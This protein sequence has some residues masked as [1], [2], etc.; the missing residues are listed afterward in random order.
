VLAEACAQLRA[1]REQDLLLEYVAV[2]VSPRQFRKPGRATAVAGILKQN[3]LVPSVL[4]LEITEGVLFDDQPSASA[5]FSAL[6]ALGVSL[7][8]DDFGTGYSSLARLQRLPVAVVKLDRSFISGI[9]RNAGAQAVVRAAIDMSH[10]LGKYVVAEGVEDAAQ[11]ALLSAMGCD[12][13]Q[14]F[15]ISH[16]LPAAELAPFVRQQAAA[17]APRSPA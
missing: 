14:G 1:W 4:H 9:E 11:L 15:H 2:N 3:E 16:P 17:E 12:I 13:A 7:E 5:N 6:T 8:L 10:A